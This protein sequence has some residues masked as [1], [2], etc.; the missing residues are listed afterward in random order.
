MKLHA[1]LS[2]PFFYFKAIHNAW[3]SMLC[4]NTMYL[5][6]PQD[7]KAKPHYVNLCRRYPS[8]AAEHH[9]IVLKPICL[10]AR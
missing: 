8:I 7:R 2:A 1:Y 3:S 5:R 9:E 10:D 4:R 6:K